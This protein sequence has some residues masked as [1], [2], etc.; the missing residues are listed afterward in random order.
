[1]SEPSAQSTLSAP[2]IC[3]RGNG[4]RRINLVP[5]ALVAA[6]LAC[7]ALFVWVIAHL[8]WG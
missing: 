6:S 7:W 3:L 4:V 8:I 1:M 2:L 5:V